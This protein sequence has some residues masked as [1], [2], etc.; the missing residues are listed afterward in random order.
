MR[1]A[2]NVEPHSLTGNCP[3]SSFTH[4]RLV[5]LHASPVWTKAFSQPLRTRRP[6][7][8]TLASLHGS[9]NMP[10]IKVTYFGIEAAAEKVRLALC[11]AGLEFEDHRID[12][13]QWPELKKTTKYGQ[14]P[15]MKVDDR[16]LYQ[17]EAQLRWVGRQGDGTLYPADADKAYE[18]DMVM[19]MHGDFVRLWQPC[20]Y[21]SM[22]PEYYGYPVGDA[23]D[24]AEKSAKVKALRENFVVEHMPGQMKALSD[25]IEEHGNKFLCGDAVT[26]ADLLWYPQLTYFTKGVADHVPTT[27]L[28]DYPAVVAW[29]ARVKEVPAIKEWY[30]KH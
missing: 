19:G 2:P 24:A 18:I 5:A 14:L 17:S 23:W 20:L 12:F 1:D 3:R 25:K 21:I 15:V 10:K 28:D 26:I 9:D 8:P 4:P 11:C 13:S 27:I 29:M 6:L 7:R 16:E 30:S 22:R